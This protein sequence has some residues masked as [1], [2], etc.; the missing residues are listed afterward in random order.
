MLY[1]CARKSL[2]DKQAFTLFDTIYG[3][4]VLGGM[5]IRLLPPDEVNLTPNLLGKQSPED[6]EASFLHWELFLVRKIGDAHPASS[7]GM[8]VIARMVMERTVS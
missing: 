1:S 5:G 7:P 8:V 2:N 3:E 4:G 6:N